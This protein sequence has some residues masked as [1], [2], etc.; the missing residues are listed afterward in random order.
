MIHPVLADDLVVERVERRC[1]A[2]AEPTA[3]RSILRV[4]SLL[5][6]KG[7]EYRYSCPDRRRCKTMPFAEARPK[8][9]WNQGSNH[10]N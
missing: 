9:W 6:K 7:V 5:L 4:F 1:R 3:G 2:V 8:T 10:W